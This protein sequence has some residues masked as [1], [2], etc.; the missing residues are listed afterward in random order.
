LCCE[1]CKTLRERSRKLAEALRAYLVSHVTDML[2]NTGKR[3]PCGCGVCKATRAALAEYEG[4]IPVYSDVRGEYADP[5]ARRL[6]E[7]LGTEGEA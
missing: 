6:V 7:R 5:A 1:D 3:G 4:E 2:L